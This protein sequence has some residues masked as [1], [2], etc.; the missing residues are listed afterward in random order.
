MTDPNR[1]D[2]GV[3]LGKDTASGAPSV[4][5]WANGAHT[6][7]AQPNPAQPNQAAPQNWGNPAGGQGAG[8]VNG[9]P[10]DIANKKLIAGLLGIFLGSLGVHKFF[11][12]NTQPAILMLAGTIGGYILGIIGSF[13]IVGAVFFLVPF[14]VSVIG[15]IEGIIYLTKSDQEFYQTYVV[16]KKAWL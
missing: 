4:G 13:I 3:N 16:G 7:Q 11:L 2:A 9:L 5:D 8:M 14:V 1:P 15:L 10:A 12:G 6:N